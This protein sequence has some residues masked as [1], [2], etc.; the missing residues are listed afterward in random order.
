MLAGQVGVVGHIQI[1]KD[2]KIGAKSGVHT[3]IQEG[4]VVSGIPAMPYETFLK[5]MAALK[6]LPKIRERL[7][8]LE[9]EVKALAAAVRSEDEKKGG[10]D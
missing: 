4:R 9:K 8:R 7:R 2:V 3:S 5:T 1:G 10:G 6:H